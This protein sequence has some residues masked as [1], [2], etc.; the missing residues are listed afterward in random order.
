MQRSCF[1]RNL[2]FTWSSL[3]LMCN[4]SHETLRKIIKK[5]LSPVFGKEEKMKSPGESTRKRSTCFAYERL[6]FDPWHCM[7]SSQN[8]GIAFEGGIRQGRIKGRKFCKIL[9]NLL[10]YILT[11]FNPRDSIK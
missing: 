7:N 6:M 1:R 5:E 11:L 8:K 3:N 10:I 9:C 4:H 2:I